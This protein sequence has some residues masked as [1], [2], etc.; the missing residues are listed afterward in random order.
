MTRPSLEFP[1][2]DFHWEMTWLGRILRVI[3]VDFLVSFSEAE[4]GDILPIT[5]VFW[6]MSGCR[7]SI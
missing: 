3:L 1:V 6:Y 4:E 7:S 5:L 2:E